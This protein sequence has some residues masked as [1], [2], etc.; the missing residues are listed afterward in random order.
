MAPSNPALILHDWK[1]FGGIRPFEMAVMTPSGEGLTYALLKDLE[2]IDG[3]LM[4]TYGVKMYQS[5]PVA[6]KEANVAMNG[7]NYYYYEI[8]IIM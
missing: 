1:D 6:I 4:E 5:I 3:Y 7:G 8:D 2:A